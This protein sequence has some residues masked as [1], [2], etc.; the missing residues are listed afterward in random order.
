MP[1]LFKVVIKVDG[2][3]NILFDPAA[4][5]VAAGDQISWTNYDAVDHL[6]G[7]VNT[8]GSCVGLVDR[9]VHGHGGVPTTFSPSPQY[10][11]N[12]NQI[13]Y[14]FSYTCCDN[15]SVTGSMNVQPTP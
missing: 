13:A 4:L 5:T 3:G 2:H 10:D 1:N 11:S 12:N 6:P 14:N 15:R 8:D 9:A 7:V